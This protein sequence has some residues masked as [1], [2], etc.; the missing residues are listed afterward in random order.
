MIGHCS[1]FRPRALS[2]LLACVLASACGSGGGGTAGPVVMDPGSYTPISDRTST[3]STELVFLGTTNTGALRFGNAGTLDH[4]TNALVGGRLAGTT[5]DARTTIMLNG[6]GIATLTNPTGADYLRVFTT[7][8]DGEPIF[9]IVGQQ[10]GPSGIPDNGSTTYLG[11][12]DLTSADGVNLTSLTGDAEITASW[13]SGGSASVTFDAFRDGGNTVAGGITI[14]GAA[15][16]NSGFSGGNLATSG[17]LFDVTDSANIANT[18]GYFFG[19]G[20]AEVGGVLIVDDTG[21]GNLEIIGV[22]APNKPKN[23]NCCFSG[24]SLGQ[25]CWQSSPAAV[26]CVADVRSVLL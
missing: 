14:T 16:S 12:I 17:A 8:G 9:G 1:P 7:Q 5:N 22:L 18:R 19:P 26:L 11:Q 23:H 21:D 6:G 3:E 10:T 25:R 20:A 13:S 15:I 4:V 24:L 2:A